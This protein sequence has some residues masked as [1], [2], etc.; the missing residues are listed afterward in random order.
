M[1]ET[2]AHEEMSRI[3]KANRARLDSLIDGHPATSGSPEIIRTGLYFIGGRGV[4]VV[5]AD[6][7]ECNK[8]LRL[9]QKS[10]E[11]LAH[12]HLS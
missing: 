7:H 11:A 10:A 12:A 4:F 6:G 5:T 9:I 3:R 1:N 8:R 2:E